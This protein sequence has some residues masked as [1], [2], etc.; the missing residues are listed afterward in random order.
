M[1]TERR[2]DAVTLTCLERFAMGLALVSSYLYRTGSS[3]ISGGNPIRF[4]IARTGQPCNPA[5]RFIE[6]ARIVSNFG[7]IIGVNPCLH[8]CL[9]LKSMMV[10]SITLRPPSVTSAEPARPPDGGAFVYG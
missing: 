1:V 3:P 2:C 4:L 7:A 9:A 6:P 10:G 5:E 8:G